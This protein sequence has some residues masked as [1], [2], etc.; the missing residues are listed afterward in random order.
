MGQSERAPRCCVGVFGMKFMYAPHHP[1]EVVWVGHKLC[2]K[3]ENNCGASTFRANGRVCVT[4]RNS[5]AVQRLSSSP[6]VGVPERNENPF[7]YAQRAHHAK[8]DIHAQHRQ[9]SA[10]FVLGKMKNCFMRDFSV[11]S[12]KKVSLNETR[13][14]FVCVDFFLVFFA[15]FL[16]E[17]RFLWNPLVHSVLRYCSGRLKIKIFCDPL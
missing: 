1:S 12:V 10:S 3:S 8:P 2:S 4:L 9:P 5:L 14:L 15:F 6:C 17:I 11:L 16:T 13:S 7:G